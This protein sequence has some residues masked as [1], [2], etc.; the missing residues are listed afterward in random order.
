[1]N[2]FSTI[3]FNKMIAKIFRNLKE[4]LK[5][6][7]G[8]VWKYNNLKKFSLE[9]RQY[10]EA[11][12]HIHLGQSGFI[13]CNGP[14]LTMADLGKLEK[15]ITIAS[16]KIY[17]AFEHTDWRPCYYTTA[18]ILLWDKIKDK[19]GGYFDRIHIPTY[20]DKGSVIH[21]VYWKSK[22]MGLFN[23]FSD[24]MSKCAYGGQTITYENLQFAVHLGLNPIYLIGCDHNYPGEKNIRAGNPI[25][26]SDNQSH[27][28]R[29]YREVGEIVMPA[30]IVDM[31]FSFMEARK[32]CDANGIKIYNA[33]RG[34]YLEIFERV[35][36]D[37]VCN[38]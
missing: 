22:T 36:F 29:N 37:E 33:T 18:D 3:R 35:N 27:F 8:Q 14:S 32:Y 25:A 12:K 9:E 16:N 17:L 28:C 1:M 5:F 34:G 38:I 31:E 7:K 4:P 30:S 20:L 21:A 19:I 26:Q 6:V 2:I 10:W 23:R 24:D 15:R 13:V 11:L